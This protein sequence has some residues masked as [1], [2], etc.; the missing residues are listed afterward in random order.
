MA[1]KEAS[2][3]ASG[4]K[5]TTVERI[6]DRELVV[7]RRVNAPAH[8]VFDAWTQPELLLR[9]WA[10]KSFGVTLLSCEVDLRP[11]GRVR[12][13]MGH[14][15]SERPMEFF[16]RYLEVTPP[17]R[18]VW[19]NEEAGEDGSI[20]TVTFEERDGA[21]IV[22]L[23]DLYPS[24]KALDEAIASQAT[25]GFGEQFDQLDELLVPPGARV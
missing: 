3:P 17:T 23:H 18:V 25:S 16:G 11:G 13:V 21:T 6:S 7:T 15:S 5:P 19:T 22:V 4:A 24:K 2:E 8:I 14:P 9:W 12:F 1:D 10:P 20:T